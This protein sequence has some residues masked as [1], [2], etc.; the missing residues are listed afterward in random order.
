MIDFLKRKKELVLR[1]VPERRPGDWLIGP[2]EQEDPISIS[3][4]TFHV[5]RRI[6]RQDFDDQDFA[7]DPCYHFIVG[8]LEGDYY[9]IDRSVLG[10]EFD[11]FMHRSIP[12]KRSTFVAERNISIFRPLHRFGITEL[13]IGGDRHDALP[14]EVFDELLRKFPNTYELDRYAAARVCGII[15]NYLPIERDD[16][17]DY[18]RYMS[19]KASRTGN[20]P[21]KVFANYEAEKYA[22]L[23]GKIESMLREAESYTEV[24]WQHEIMQVIQ[25]LFP[26]YVRAFREAPVRDSLAKKARAIDFLLVD[27]SGYVD[28]IEIKK[29]FAECIVTKN[30]YR[31]NHVPMRELSGTVMQLEKYLFHLNRWGEQGEKLLNK[32]YA[33]ELP[34]GLEIRIVN[35]GGMIV[36]GRDRDWTPE[37]RTD[38]EVIRRKYRHVLEIMTYDDLLGRLK[39]IRDRFQLLCAE[40]IAPNE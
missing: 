32:R 22:D 6:Y 14:G 28:G 5:S 33:S 34:A 10:I 3:S 16:E 39:V 38:F 7:M 11:L 20:Q 21:Q 17:A 23:I 18:H 19:R 31:D 35:P 15:R 37:Q 30:R 4:R 36:M 8:H 25:F 26:K 27:A 9:R 24:Q 1:Y 40:A 2:L 29:P 12:F 13:W